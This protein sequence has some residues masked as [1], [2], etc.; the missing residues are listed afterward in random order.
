MPPTANAGP[1]QRIQLP[2]D[3]VSLSGRLST[4]D[5]GIVEY[6]WELTSP[7][8]GR[9][10]L[11]GDDSPN[12]DV[13]NLSEGEYTFTLTVK[14]KKGQS[15]SDSAK[16]IVKAGKHSLYMLHQGFDE[17]LWHF[18]CLSSLKYNAPSPYSRYISDA[19]T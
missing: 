2:E 3:S 11:R 6:S 13:N 18:A 7:S 19:I 5:K 12:L 4:D 17:N 10:T 1:D 8:D 16:V 14:D 9:V 15:D